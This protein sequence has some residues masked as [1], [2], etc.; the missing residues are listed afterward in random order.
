M[1]T[2]NGGKTQT[3]FVE[4][5]TEYFKELQVKNLSKLEWQLTSATKVS[6]YLPYLIVGQLAS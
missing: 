6:S 4:W 3:I 2:T 1:D 5:D